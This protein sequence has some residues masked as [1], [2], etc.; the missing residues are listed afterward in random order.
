MRWVEAMR[1]GSDYRANLP[2]QCIHPVGHWYEFPNLLRNGL[3]ADLI[4]EQPQLDYF[5][6]HNVDTLGAAL[7]ETL[8]GNHIES[9]ATFSVEVVRKQFGDHGGSL[10]RVNGRARLVEGLA[11]P[12]EEVEFGLS[13]YNSSTYWITIDRVLKVFGLRREQLRDEAV[14]E[15]AVRRT[16]QRVPSYI[17]IKDVKKRWGRGQEDVYPV[18]QFERLWGDMTGLEEV[19]TAWFEVPRQRG[20]QLK[21][22]GQLDTWLRDGSAAAIEKMLR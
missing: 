6:L 11:L 13:Y 15:A 1:E 10:A 9:G 5:L 2:H 17:T 18:A 16:A 12:G 4:E 3:L 21:E 20:Q 7:D 14:V 8:L 19:R 22:V